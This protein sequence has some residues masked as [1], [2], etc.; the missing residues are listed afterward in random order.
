MFEFSLQLLPF[1]F[2]A[3]VM[4]GLIGLLWRWRNRVAGF[5]MLMVGIAVEVW[6]GFFI[7]ELAATSLDLKIILANI[8]FLGIDALPVFWLGLTLAYT[9]HYRRWRYFVQGL[10]LVPVLNQIIIWTTHL[11]HLFRNKPYLDTTTASFS[12]L[13]SDYSYWYYCVQVPFV[14]LTF[15]TT[16]V[17]LIRAFRYASGLLRAQISYILVS[18][19]L[20]LLINFLYVLGFSPIANVNLTTVAF[21]FS[22]SLVVWSLLR[23]RFLDFMPVARS[24]IMDT[25]PDAWLVLDQAGRVVDL[26]EAALDISGGPKQ[27]V[28]GQPATALLAGK[29]ELLK[30]LEQA[31]TNLEQDVSW[32]QA[33]QTVHYALHIT[34]LKPDRGEASGK[35]LLLRDITQRKEAAAELERAKELAEV[36]NRT[37]STFLAVMSHEIRT[38]MN[39]IL[40]MANLLL[41]TPL[42]TEQEDYAQT[43]LTS[44]EALLNILND[45]LDFSKIEADKVELD[46]QPVELREVLEN[47]LDLVSTR[48]AAKSL[49]LTY[50]LEENCPAFIQSDATRLRQ[51][52]L[53]LLTN[54]V[55]FT[56]QGEISVV[57]SGEKLSDADEYE[58]RFAIRDTGIGIAPEDRQRL[59]QS[60]SQV[61]ASTTRKYGGTGLGLAISKRL[62][63]LMGGRMWVESESGSGSTFYFTI[64]AQSITT[65]P[66]VSGQ[67]ELSGKRLLIV[68]DNATN[69]RILAIQAERWGMLPTECASGVAALDLLE[70]E[71]I[72]FDLAILDMQMPQMDGMQLAE[73]IHALPL[74]RNLPLVMLTS[75]GQRQGI[76][77]THFVA[78]LNKPAKIGLLHNAF[79]TCFN[80]SLPVSLPK[81]LPEATGNAP[82]LQHALKILVAEDN[83]LNQKIAQRM[84][85]RL[86]YSASIANNGFEALA[87]LDSASYD[88]IFMDMQMPEMDGLQATRIIRQK[89]QGTTGPRI[90]AMTANVMQNDRELCLQAGM[91]D[92]LTKPIRLN[93]LRAALQR[94]SAW[95]TTRSNQVETAITENAEEVTPVEE[96]GELESLNLEMLAELRLLNEAG[97]ADILLEVSEIFQQQMPGFLKELQLAA[98]STNLEKVSYFAHAIKGSAGN[99]GATRLIALTERLEKAGE[100]RLPQSEIA[101]LV[102][103]VE[104]EYATVSSLLAAMVKQPSAN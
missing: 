17:L 21:T 27:K 97:E 26:N 28:L 78:I 87:A 102:E 40:G 98:S 13:A 16:T 50:L 41:D 55:K 101:E 57:V 6:T 8:E 37:K 19:L 75:L 74:Y 62:T 2:S 10:L 49:E 20:P 30:C 56:E 45:I 24:A 79:A 72:K 23:Y 76:D 36:A 80:S 71:Q 52:L 81:A 67:I 43:I 5:Y 25:L 65:I 14:M 4:A 29:P 42:N 53:N 94:S 99:L 32:Q 31:T 51:I 64:E 12:I 77:S 33:G 11:H 93:E 38:P 54:A 58:L 86:G 60:F 83:A 84:L 73:A 95:L 3:C 35:L 66:A 70:K 96:L 48:A 9:G 18:T 100:A 85:E 47:C 90:V 89:R 88:L 63:E 44:G 82:A 34:I 104:K 91:D 46:M 68:D 22:G 15:L 103:Q 69:R 92:F 7:F 1:V 39:G 59:F 61:D